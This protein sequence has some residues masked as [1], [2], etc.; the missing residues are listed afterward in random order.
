MALSHR[1]IL[2]IT[3]LLAS[4]ATPAEAQYGRG[5]WGGGYGGVGYGGVGYGG[6][7][8]V[9]G[10]MS[11]GMGVYAAG[12][13]QYNMDTA[14][15]RAMNTNTAMQFNQYV[16]QSRI[17]AARIY[18]G[19]Q[20]RDKA[21]SAKNA[22][23]LRVRLRDN[24]NALDVSSG[25]ALNMAMDELC[26][27]MLFE[28]TL[29]AAGKKKVGGEAIRD[30][31]F[32]YA[33]AAISISVHQLTQGGAPSVLADNKV[34]ETDRTALRA[35]AAELR[36][37]GDATGQHKP[38]T[39][40]KAKDQILATKAKIEA[41]FPQDSHDRVVADRYIKALY[42]FV[43]MLDTPAVNVL[44][45]GV[46][47]HPDAS[48]GDLIHFMSAYNLRF[49]PATS[50]RQKDVYMQLY[51]MLVQ[52]R[53]DLVPSPGSSVEAQPMPL[54]QDAPLAAFDRMSFD[55]INGKTPPPPA[56]QNPK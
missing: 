21:R 48:L 27:P 52:L 51:P 47:K 19:E 29:Y 8:T 22:E 31:P 50:P 56:P 33:S 44:L 7:S 24:P 4:V 23:A 13:G 43:K 36:K 42:G 28:K 11:R 17:E 49:G 5:Y 3:A 39:I 41:T 12:M 14:Q 40:Q 35:I 30:I 10:D 2:T 32:S 15:A 9:G 6:A 54:A 16:Y 38:E 26:N 1:W 55:Q 34:F 46:E 37:E 20:A 53:S 45:A 25:D 18:H